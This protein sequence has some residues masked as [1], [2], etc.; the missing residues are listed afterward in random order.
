MSKNYY[1]ILE[2]SPTASFDEIKKSFRKLALKYH[3]DKN[4]GDAISENK[5]KEINAAYSVLSDPFKK[6][7]YD[8]VHFPPEPATKQTP[9]PSSR[10]TAKTS[11]KS[12]AV[13]VG[14]NLLY[15]LNLTLEDAFSGV[16]KSISYMRVV[17]GVKTTSHL[18]VTIPAGIRDAKKLRVR[19]AGESLSARQH[20]GDLVVQIHVLP[21]KFYIL[22]GNDILLK[23]PV[24]WIDYVLKEPV[25]VPTLHGP[26]ALSIPKEDDFGAAGAILEGKGFPID[27]K[28]HRFGDQYI[29]FIVDVPSSLN[30][31]LK[32]KLR[33]LKKDMPLSDW[34]KEILSLSENKK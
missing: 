24:S 31:N 23:M 14:K 6:S 21:H 2:L 34:Q 29:R 15:H 27:E 11:A 25:T 9:R 7:D 32:E 3:P 4:P 17:N 33:A 26:L 8:R 18:E 22:E 20:A 12:A 28:S 13:S 19:G 30:E 1:E 16:T 10:S 5:F